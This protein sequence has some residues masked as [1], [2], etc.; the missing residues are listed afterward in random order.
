MYLVA[1]ILLAVI[2]VALEFHDRSLIDKPL[3][4]A[5]FPLGEGPKT[6]P[7]RAGEIEGC[8]LLRKS[9]RDFSK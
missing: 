3:T 8:I 7:S 1:L 4:P 5:I 2:G 9:V 6:R